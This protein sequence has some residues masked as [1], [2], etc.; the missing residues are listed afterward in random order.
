MKYLSVR[1]LSG[2]FARDSGSPLVFFDLQSRFSSMTKGWID[3]YH[4]QVRL[5]PQESSQH[6]FGL[7]I[8]EEVVGHCLSSSWYLYQESSLN[9]RGNLPIDVRYYRSARWA[10]WAM[11]VSS[12]GAASLWY[13]RDERSLASL[14]RYF[15]FS[16]V[17]FWPRDVIQKYP[18][19]SQD[20]LAGCICF[21]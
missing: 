16:P 1:C 5:N 14:M 13:S 3:F 20:T 2:G 8:F 21:H 9:L 10:T 15:T 17:A 6:G 7:I 11:F 18:A 4:V 12:T 19:S